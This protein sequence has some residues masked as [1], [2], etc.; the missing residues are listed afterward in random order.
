MAMKG[1]ITLDIDGTLTP[2]RHS[3]PKEVIDYLHHLVDEGW[4]VALLTGRVFSFAKGPLKAL[5]FPYYLAVQNGADILHMAEKK[6]VHRRYLGADKLSQLDAVYLGTPEDYII[7][8]GY[9]RGDFCYFRPHRLSTEFRAYLKKLEALVEAPWQPVDEFAFAEGEAFPLI[10][11]AGSQEVME[12]L[13][14]KIRSIGGV[15][16]SCIHD[17][18]DPSLYLNL[19]THEEANKGGAVRWLKS[20]LSPAYTIAAGDDRNDIPMLEEVDFAIA[21][22]GAP[23]DLLAAA[24]LVARPAHKLGIIEALKEAIRHAPA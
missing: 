2:E 24:D 11:C 23:Q 17:P 8:A 4:E 3:I 10:K 12:A 18:I 16:V 19:I 14:P 9:E 5:D 13:T 22:E 7:Y 20:K 1:L 21:M 15:A 6:Q